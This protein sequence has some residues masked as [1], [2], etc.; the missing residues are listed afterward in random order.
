VLDDIADVDEEPI[1]KA[2]LE[3]VGTYLSLEFNAAKWV[4]KGKGVYVS[5]TWLC[6]VLS[7]PTPIT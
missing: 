6:P 1:S 3:A 5:A 7:V 2:V 4:D